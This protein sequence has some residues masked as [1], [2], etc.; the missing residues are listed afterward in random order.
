MSVQILT[1]P[2]KPILWEAPTA[3]V[4]PKWHWLRDHMI[5]AYNFWGAGDTERSLTDKGELTAVGATRAVGRFGRATDLSGVSQDRWEDTTGEQYLDGLTQVSVVLLYKSDLINVDNVLIHTDSTSNLDRGFNVRYDSAGFSGGQDDV[6]KIAFGDFTGDDTVNSIIES[7]AL[8]QTTNYQHLVTTW[9]AGEV[10]KLYLD[11]VLDTPSFSTSSSTAISNLTNVIV[12]SAG[13][14]EWNGLI[15]QVLVIDQ[16][17]PQ[18]LITELYRD[19]F[20]PFRPDF[21]AVGRAPA[22][23]AEYLP[24]DLAHTPQHQ[25]IMAH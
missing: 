18:A 23:V 16:V 25:A 3:F 21:R 2:A 5:F 17:I 20:A 13:R 15:D 12:G 9:R 11:G 10:P 19:T 1:P 22:A 4:D 8:V 6:I 24:L 7:S 14:G